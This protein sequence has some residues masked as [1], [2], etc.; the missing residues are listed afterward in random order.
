MGNNCSSDIGDKCNGSPNKLPRTDN[1][2]GSP[3]TLQSTDKTTANI[4]LLPIQRISVGK[5]FNSKAE[6]SFALQNY[7]NDANKLCRQYKQTA[8]VLHHICIEKMQYMRKE[9]KTLEEANHLCQALHI[10]RRRK[11]NNGV[12]YF[13]VT[14]SHPHTCDTTSTISTKGSR[15]SPF[16]TKHLSLGIRDIFNRDKFHTVDHIG[17]FVETQMHLPTN[18][19][20]YQQRFWIRNHLKDEFYGS[21]HWQYMTLVSRLEIIK[22]MIL[23]L[24]FC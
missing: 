9:N 1:S 2:N 17:Q 11:D 7:H 15:K 16:S 22:K 20:E 8:L 13:T 14:D 3:Y 12:Y 23:I 18:Q 24:S 19:L 21:T 10:A 6:V 5:V 4:S